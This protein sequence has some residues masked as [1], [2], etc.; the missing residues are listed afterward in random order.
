MGS[1]FLKFLGWNVTMVVVTVYYWMIRIEHKTVLI[2]RMQER[3]LCHWYAMFD[4][5][6][7]NAGEISYFNKIMEVEFVAEEYWNQTMKIWVGTNYCM[8][9]F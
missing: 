4:I 7:E 5:I 3:E 6:W 2:I 9:K 8:G 1:D